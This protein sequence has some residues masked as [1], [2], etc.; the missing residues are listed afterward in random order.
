MEYG[1]PTT[2]RGLNFRSR[3]E[4]TWAAFFDLVEW[5]WRYEP[6]DLKGYIP[7]FVLRW[8]RPLLVE[9]K[10]ESGLEALRQYAPKIVASGWDGDFLLVGDGPVSE[11]GIRLGAT[12]VGEPSPAAALGLLYE[13][14][15]HHFE[16]NP[17]EDKFLFP[18]L[19]TTHGRRPCVALYSLL[20][21]FQVAIDP[22][23]GEHRHEVALCGCR[24]GEPLNDGTWRDMTRTRADEFWFKAQNAT[25]WRG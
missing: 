25:Q 12:G 8:N 3:L 7:D 23:D 14:E 6:R 9:V 19:L 4:A 18:A 13:S 17:F 15:P 24:V 21:L 16:G 10:G 20:A 11:R 1:I 5:E 22:L 2:Y